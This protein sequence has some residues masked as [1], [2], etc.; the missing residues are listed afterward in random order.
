MS[1]AI[2][3]ISMAHLWR[4]RFAPLTKVALREKANGARA[5]IGCFPMAQLWRNGAPCGRE[6]RTETRHVDAPMA[7][8]QAG[9][10]L[11]MSQ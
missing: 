8:Y 3:L 7:G 1:C 9:A 4:N 10:E 2:D 11:T 6:K 5:A